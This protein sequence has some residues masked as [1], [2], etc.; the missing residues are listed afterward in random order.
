MGKMM[1]D[2]AVDEMRGLARRRVELLEA[3]PAEPIAPGESET[4][5]RAEAGELSEWLEAMVAGLKGEDKGNCGLVWAH[6]LEGRSSK[7]LAAEMECSVDAI[8]GRIKRAPKILRRM[9]AEHLPGG[10]PP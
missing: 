2:Q 7:E 6:H 10:E 9:A 1:H 5:Q 4:G 3:L 8:K